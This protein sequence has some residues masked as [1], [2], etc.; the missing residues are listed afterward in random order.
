MTGIPV[1]WSN[2]YFGTGS[3]HLSVTI[4]AMSEPMIDGKVKPRHIFAQQPFFP[5]L[6]TWRGRGRRAHK[7]NK[8]DY[9]YILATLCY[10]KFRDGSTR[11]KEAVEFSLLAIFPERQYYDSGSGCFRRRLPFN[12]LRTQNY[13]YEFPSSDVFIKFNRIN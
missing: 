3:A 7:H 11:I 2:R 1:G 8:F 5:R 12:W 10:I 9:G 4:K 6:Y 13:Y